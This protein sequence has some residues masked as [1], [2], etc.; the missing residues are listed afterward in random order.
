MASRVRVSISPR[1][2]ASLARKRIRRS[3]IARSTAKSAPLPYKVITGSQGN[4][5]FE[6]LFL[7]DTPV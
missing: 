2:P 1:S 4:Q 5:P 6:I 3:K 7:L